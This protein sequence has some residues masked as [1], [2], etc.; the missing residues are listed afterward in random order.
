MPEELWMDGSLWNCTR[1]NGQTTPKKK[2]DKKAKWLS[3][4]VLQIAEKRR[5]VKGKGEKK[6]YTHLNAE[7]Q[8]TA[9]NRTVPKQ[10]FLSNQCKET[11]ENNSMGENR[12]LFSVLTW[13]IPGTGE[14]SGLPSMGLHGVGHDWSDLAAAAAEIT[15]RKLEIPR[16]HFMQ[17][18]SQ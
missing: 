4:E 15:S 6:S 5:E 9:R 2:K 8:R 18:W 17:R 12:D 14:P 3:E 13:R 11:E 10:A 7:F 16:G 1:G